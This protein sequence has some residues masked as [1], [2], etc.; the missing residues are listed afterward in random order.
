M[1][2]AACR[3][4]ARQCIELAQSTTREQQRKM[5]L[6]MAVKW[7]QLAGMTQQEIDLIAA[8][9]AAKNDKAGSPQT[10]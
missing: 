6:D 8:D 4:R 1:M 9:N 10:K 5:L 3:E 7:L 2:P